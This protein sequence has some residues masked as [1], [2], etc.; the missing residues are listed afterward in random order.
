MPARLALVKELV[1][2]AATALASGGCV[3]SE[4]ANGYGATVR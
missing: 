4:S 1:N 3:L 2:E